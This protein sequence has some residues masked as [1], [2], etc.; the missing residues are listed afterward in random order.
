MLALPAARGQQPSI[1]PVKRV[2]L[3][4]PYPPG[5]ISDAVARLIAER[6]PL[7]QPV[8]VENKPG[9]GG[10]IGMNAVA[11]AA[12]DGHTLAFAAISPLTLSPLAHRVPYDPL[13]DVVPVAR[14]MYSPVYLLATPAFGGKTL[15]DALAQARTQP[16]ETTFATSGMGSLGHLML[17]QISRKAK[18][19]FNHI[20]YKGGSQVAN[21]AAAGQF[22]LFAANP[23]PA[24]NS[25]VA[26]G[27]L[28]LLAVAAPQRLPSFADTPTLE[29][30]GYPEANLNSV[31][32]VF[33]PAHTPPA[34]Q[35]R[36][37]V[38]INHLLADKDVQ[39]RLGKLDCIVSPGTIA[40]F[41][42][43]VRREYAANKRVVKEAD[44]HFE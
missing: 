43:Q 9:G 39:A 21:D 38:E 1:W 20:P 3:I 19:S 29:E 40:E 35:Q 4:V 10:A 15:A 18:A 16:G 5:G 24:V 6:L 33:A 34:V 44:I 12:A 32:G 42:A 36:L 8:I 25:L 30:L 7:G 23:S 22:E 13:N 11:K 41:S 37:N 27:R 28:R 2:Q 14:V 31:F 17:E 26:Q